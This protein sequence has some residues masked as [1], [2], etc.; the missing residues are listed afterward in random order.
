MRYDKKQHLHEEFD[1]VNEIFFV[2]SGKI[3]IGYDIN[4]TKKYCLQYTDKL[5]VG[6]YEVSFN[7]KSN[8]VYTALTELHG[9]FIRKSKWFEALKIDS[10][11]GTFI[12]RNI[13][14]DY[15]TKIRVKVMVNKKKAFNEFIIRKD[16]E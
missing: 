12:Q 8:F 10:D 9:Y 13:I 11:L 15:M 16:Y 1:D 6:A 3:V 4:K 7:K 14:M 5:V 2:D